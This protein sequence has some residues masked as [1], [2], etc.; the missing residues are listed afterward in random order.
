LATG[1]WQEAPCLA[2]RWNGY[3]GSGVGNPQAREN[4]TWFILPT[5]FNRLALPLVPPQM[6]DR[7]RK[8]L[9]INETASA[10]ASNRVPFP[11]RH[12]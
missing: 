11:P 6:R 9:S 8:F 1:Y 3:E 7:M 4:A 12:R 2:I 10:P 5:E